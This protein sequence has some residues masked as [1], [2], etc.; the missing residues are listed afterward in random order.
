MEALYIS[1]FVLIAWIF[2]QLLI[3]I[4]FNSLHA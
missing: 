4:Y 1:H 2:V 3:Y